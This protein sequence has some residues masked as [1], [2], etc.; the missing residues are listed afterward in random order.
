[1]NIGE[2]KML[3]LSTLA[4]GSPFAWK[5]SSKICTDIQT[6]LSSTVAI[7]LSRP[8]VCLMY[9]VG[10]LLYII[11]LFETFLLYSSLLCHHHRLMLQVLILNTN[12][13]NIDRILGRTTEDVSHQ[14]TLNGD[15]GRELCCMLLVWWHSPLP[16]GNSESGPLIGNLQMQC[17]IFWVMVYF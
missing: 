9:I 3:C 15:E 11:Y 13:R 12:T 1:M 5:H 4:P 8:I 14:P 2:I 10:C 6:P 16:R 7:C 17:F